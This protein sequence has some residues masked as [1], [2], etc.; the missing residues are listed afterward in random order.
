[1]SH[2]AGLTG[3][4]IGP[5]IARGVLTHY[6]VLTR[7]WV[8]AM[9]LLLALAALVPA[10]GVTLAATNTYYVNCRSGLDSRSGTSAS[11][12]WE[13]LQ[14]ANMASLYPGDKL[15]LK[16]GCRWTGPLDARWSGTADAPIV[17][18]AYGRGSLP[19][20]ENAHDNILVTGSYLTFH[21]LMTRADAPGR[22]SACGSVPM[23]WVVGFRFTNGSSHNIVRA[24]M[25]RDLYNG[26]LIESGSH[27]NKILNNK[28]VNINVQVQQFGLGRRCNGNQPSKATTTKSLITPSVVATPALRLTVVT[29]Q[30]SKCSAAR[31][32]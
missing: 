27:D 16:R 9:A 8:P 29:D 10:P 7:W 13:S 19:V 6:R 12:A 3:R 17:I 25:L 14:R 30:R 32:T 18:A 31:A 21:H 5:A 28:L 20:I 15:L 23:G 2:A 24:S 22:D 1:M 11:Q 26:V 4:L